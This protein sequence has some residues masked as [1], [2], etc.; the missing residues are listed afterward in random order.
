MDG[1]IG[2]QNDQWRDGWRD[3]Q[4]KDQQMDRQIYRKMDG[5]TGRLIHKERDRGMEEWMDGYIKLT[6]K[7]TDS[8]SVQFNNNVT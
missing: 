5:W 7:Q 2:I 4:I 3:R 8:N 1:W 6:K